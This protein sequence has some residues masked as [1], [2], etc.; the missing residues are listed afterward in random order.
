MK[1]E[2]KD[3]KEGEI[4]VALYN[5]GKDRYIFL[6][7]GDN[8]GVAYCCNQINSFSLYGDLVSAFKEGY[9]SATYKEIL[10]LQQCIKENRFVSI[11]NIKEK[12]INNYSIF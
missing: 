5:N 11:K 4:Y 12:S 7:K 2:L 3:L 10:Q 8:R 1:L 6:S 9:V